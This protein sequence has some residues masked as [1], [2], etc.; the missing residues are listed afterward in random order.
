MSGKLTSPSLLTL[1]RRTVSPPAN[2]PIAAE[3]STRAVE[4][5]RAFR[6]CCDIEERDQWCEGAYDCAGKRGRRRD[7][8]CDD[9]RVVDDSAPVPQ[10]APDRARGRRCEDDRIDHVLAERQ[11]D[12]NGNVELYRAGCRLAENCRKHEGH[13][14]GSVA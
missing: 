7:C 6:D 14:R 9:Q 10:P 11:R 13:V 12:Q 8:E 4:E 5:P 3:P 2:R 1:A